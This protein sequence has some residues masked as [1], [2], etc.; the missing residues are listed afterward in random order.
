VALAEPGA[1]RL[2]MFVDT[3]VTTHARL[4]IRVFQVFG[5]QGPPAPVAKPV[6][7]NLKPVAHRN[8]LVEHETLPVPKA[9]LFRHGFEV[10]QNTAFEVVDFIHAL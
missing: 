4:E 3:L 1:I 10:L 5:G 8:P 6:V 7:A 2:I 9:V